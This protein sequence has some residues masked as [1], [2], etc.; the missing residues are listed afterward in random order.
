MYLKMLL[1]NCDELRL[2]TEN[3]GVSAGEHSTFKGILQEIGGLCDTTYRFLDVLF[4]Q[5]RMMYLGAVGEKY[6]KLYQ[7]F[8]QEEKIRVISAFVRKEIN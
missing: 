2:H 7:M 1:K 3:I 6:M 4:E 8:N 5:K